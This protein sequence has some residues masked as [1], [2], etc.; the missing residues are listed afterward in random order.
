MH[1]SYT[2]P[3]NEILEFKPTKR[4]LYRDKVV[5]KNEYIRLRESRIKDLIQRGIDLNIAE[6]AI[7]LEYSGISNSIFQQINE[8]IIY[9]MYQVA[10]KLQKYKE[11][12]IIVQVENDRIIVPEI[13]LPERLRTKK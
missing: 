4:I 9:K 2:I 12:T 8:D 10:D 13:I 3:W 11:Y 7:P 5:D 1:E 6:T